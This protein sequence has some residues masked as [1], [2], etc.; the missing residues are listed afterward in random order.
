MQMLLERQV[1]LGQE[2]LADRA[3][4]GLPWEGT[5]RAVAAEA[6]GVVVD[7][8]V[9]GILRSLDLISTGL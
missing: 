4:R 6:W 1:K 7:R 5:E 9:Q 2:V 8:E 3:D